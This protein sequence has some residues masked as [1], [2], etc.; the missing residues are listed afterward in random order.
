MYS[1]RTIRTFC[2]VLLCLPLVH[3]A[4][5]VSRDMLATLDSSPDAWADELAAYEDADRLATLPENPLVVIGG[6]RVKLWEGLDGL[7]APR[8]VLMRG[9]GNATLEDIAHN[10][11]RLAAFYHPS[12]VVFLPSD[13][14]FYIRDSKSE[15]DFMEALRALAAL[16]AEHG[17]DWQFIAYTPIKTPLR[18]GDYQKI[19]AITQRMLSWADSDPRVLVIDAN[20]LM[21]SA[22]GGPNPAFFR[23]DG[24]SLNEAGY[25]RLALPLKNLIDS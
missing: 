4:V 1:W 25:L 6:R 12:V 13:S 21:A 23:P 8:P 17:K 22:G 9:L 5:L 16:D 24:S 10:Y 19:D 2:V 20:P 7:L 14:E 18:Q 15:D 11:E 3:L